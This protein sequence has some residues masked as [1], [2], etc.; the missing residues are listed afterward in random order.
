MSVL[1]EPIQ[2]K[3]AL[4]LPYIL[5]KL[6]WWTIVLLLLFLPF[7]LIIQNTFALPRSFL[8]ID[9]LLIFISF[10]IFL[11]SLLCYE[12]K[13][14]DGVAVL[15]GLLILIV[16]IGMMSALYNASPFIISFVT[17]FNYTKYFLVIPVF[18]SFLVRQNDVRKLYNMLY[19]LALILCIIAL[20]QEAFYFLGLSVDTLGAS[21]HYVYLRF[22]LMRTPSLMGHP[23]IFALY[24]LLFFVLDFSRYRRL[25]WQN[26]L[27]LSGIFLSGSRTAWG[28]LFLILFYFL[29]LK[30]PKMIRVSVVLI[31]VTVTTTL[32]FPYLTKTKEFTSE[33]YFRRYIILKSIEIWKDHPLVGVGP[34]MYGGW[35]TDDFSSPVFEKYN[36][37]PRW[38]ESIKRHRTLDNFW[39]QHLAESGLLGAMC[40]V[41]LL[42]GLW[43]IALREM[44]LSHDPFRKAMLSGLNAMLIAMV[45]HLFT[46]SLNATAFL[47]TYFMLFGMVL[48]MKSENFAR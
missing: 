31:I 37:A 24:S 1:S 29:Y 4:V 47:I 27:L 34:G 43:K 15:L 8:W 36:F 41:A 39:F 13:I 23:N 28:A 12:K 5:R 2:N 46:T 20:L 7:Q 22:G 11:F 44:L 21:T 30:T 17:I 33:T 32:L 42:F 3:Y 38:I 45:V 35:I 19:R 40:F 25:R 14:Q 26:V 6:G 10:I 9:E 16:F 48:G 18:W